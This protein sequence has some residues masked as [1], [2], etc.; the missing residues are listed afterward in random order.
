MLLPISA[1]L[2]L[3]S[4]IQIEVS[5]GSQCCGLDFRTYL[6]IHVTIATIMTILVVMH[7]YLHFGWKEWRENKQSEKQ[8][9]TRANMC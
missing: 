1:L 2:I 7:L 8:A 5:G 3:A 6:L 4:G 9:N